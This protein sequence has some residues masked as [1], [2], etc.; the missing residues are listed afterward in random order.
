MP[1]A[2]IS[3]VAACISSLTARDALEVAH[4]VS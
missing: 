3:L 1:C 4:V 2:S